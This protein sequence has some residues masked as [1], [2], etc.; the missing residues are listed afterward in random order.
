MTEA[1]VLSVDSREDVE[2]MTICRK[3]RSKVQV[4]EGEDSG[5][6]QEE[7]TKGKI[8]PWS[9]PGSQGFHSIFYRK[10]ETTC[11][12]LLNET[13]D[14]EWEKSTEVKM[15]SFKVK[16]AVA[17]TEDEGIKD[18]MQKIE[19]LTTVV[20]SLTFGGT[21]PNR[22]SAGVTSVASGQYTGKGKI[23]EPV[24]PYKG[25]GPTTSAAGPFKQCHNCGGWGHSHRQCLSQG[26][27]NWRSLS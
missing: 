21:K 22:G 6:I 1:G 7:Y 25:Q 9:A 8:V 2:G 5:N 12:E 16:S 10:A 23:K 19:Q 11:Y 4:T 17:T 14:A 3:T 15:T 13:L 24:S 26:C 18:L 27:I 20:K